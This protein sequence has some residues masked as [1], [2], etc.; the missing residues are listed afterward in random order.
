VAG[1]VVS[2]ARWARRTAVL[3]R[4]SFRAYKAFAPL[5]AAI[6]AALRN[7]QAVLDGEIVCLNK[8]GEPQFNAPLFRR[9]LPWFYAFDLLWLD[10]ED[11]RMLPLLERKRRLRRLVPRCESRL[12]FVDHVARRGRDLFRA[13]CERDLEGIV[14]KLA[15]SPYVEQPS[16]WIKVLDPRYSQKVDRH[17]LFEQR[18]QGAR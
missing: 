8:A 6:A 13:V 4:R 15:H 18:A 17:E 9:A 14:G 10:G 3:V 7:H 2:T 1:P 5:A 11:L 16:P 12:L